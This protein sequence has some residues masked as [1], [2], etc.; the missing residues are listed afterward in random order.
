MKKLRL[1]VTEACN[2]H[3]EGCCNKDW[4]LASLPVI[5]SYTG[6]DEI[7][8]TGGEPMIDVPAVSRIIHLARTQS[9][10]K[11]YL[12]TADTGRPVTLCILL[13]IIDGLTVTLHHQKDVRTFKRFLGYLGKDNEDKSLRLNIFKGVKL[14]DLDVSEWT[15]KND[16]EW[17]K[18]CPLPKDEVFMRYREAL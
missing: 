2:N 7:L 12:Y 14:G 3:C 5:K 4:D 1:L 11:I 10:A 16:I 9:K 6:Y 17:V 8:L 13:S 15:V 18:D